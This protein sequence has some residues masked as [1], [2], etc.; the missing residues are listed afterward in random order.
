LRFEREET[1]AR[2]NTKWQGVLADKDVKLAK[3]DAKLA[4]LKA[5]LQI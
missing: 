5:Q 1:E 4:R 2:V 3:K